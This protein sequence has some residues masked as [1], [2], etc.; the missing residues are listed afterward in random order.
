MHRNMPIFDGNPQN[1]KPLSKRVLVMS[2]TIIIMSSVE[3]I[4]S[5][6][7]TVFTEAQ[8]I[9]DFVGRM[10]RCPSHRMQQ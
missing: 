9:H 10:D 6:D 5:R 1:P 3:R 2:L 4:G 8:Q 7:K